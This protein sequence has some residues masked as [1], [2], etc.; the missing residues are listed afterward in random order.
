[1]D[2]VYIVAIAVA[3]IVVLIIIF[4]FFTY[5]FLDIFRRPAAGQVMKAMNAR[6]KKGK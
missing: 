1:M 3:L 4:T 2:A 5:I 6:G